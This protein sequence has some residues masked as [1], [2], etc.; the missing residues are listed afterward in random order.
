MK[1]LPKPVSLQ[2][3]DMFVMV[4][5]WPET[6]FADLTGQN[7]ADRVA[8]GTEAGFFQSLGM[9]C[10]VCSPGSIEQAH[11]SDEFI[12]LGQ[13]ES[14]LNILEKLQGVL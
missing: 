12:Q 10:V 3:L 4:K 8:F 2:Q 9:D 14:Y 11:K 1:L 7:G 5:T 13:M 6:L